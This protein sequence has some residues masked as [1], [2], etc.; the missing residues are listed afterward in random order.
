MI[1]SQRNFTTENHP[2]FRAANIEIRKVCV[3]LDDKQIDWKRL[4]KQESSSDFALRK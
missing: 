3:M 1:D 4:K 2:N